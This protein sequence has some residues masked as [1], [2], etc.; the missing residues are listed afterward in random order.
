V[1][2]QEFYE[3]FDSDV[4]ILTQVVFAVRKKDGSGNVIGVWL[5]TRELPGYFLSDVSVDPLGVSYSADAFFKSYRL[6]AGTYEEIVP[7]EPDYLN[8]NLPF[9]EPNLHSQ[10]H[11]V[12]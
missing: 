5:T 4:F 11:E 6:R 7:L 12:L 8:P 10:V 3:V 2:G 1:R 9:P